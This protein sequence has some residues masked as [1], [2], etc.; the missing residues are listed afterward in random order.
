[1]YTVIKI[2]RRAKIT[3]LIIKIFREHQ[4]NSRRFPVFF[5]SNFELHEM[6]GISRSCRH[7]VTLQYE[8]SDSAPGPMLPQVGQFKYLSL[9]LILLVTAE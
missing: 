4:L 7:P 8:I 3:L 5:M 2:A 1:M 9:C 6:S